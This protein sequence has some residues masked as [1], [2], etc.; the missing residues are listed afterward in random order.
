MKTDEKLTKILQALKS[1]YDFSDIPD[2]KKLYIK[3]YQLRELIMREIQ[4]VDRHVVSGW[5]RRLVS[6]GYLSPNPTSEFKHLGLYQTP[7]HMP[8]DDSRYLIEIFSINQKLAPTTHSLS[9]YST[10]VS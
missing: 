6:E 3:R 9:E 5:V 1:T 8:T 4:V 2:D 10:V 7:M